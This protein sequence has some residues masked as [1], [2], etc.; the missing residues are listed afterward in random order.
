MSSWGATSRRED[1]RGFEDMEL[2]GYYLECVSIK[3]GMVL[4][5]APALALDLDS[6]HFGC[7]FSQ[8]W[9]VGTPGA[10]SVQIRTCKVATCLPFRKRVLSLSRCG[11]LKLHSDR[12]RWRYL[13]FD[14]HDGHEKEVLNALFHPSSSRP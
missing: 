7:R 11:R 4:F 1:R 13:F 5:Q 2:G 10:H 8:I 14:N 9:F 3:E 6:F 12:Q